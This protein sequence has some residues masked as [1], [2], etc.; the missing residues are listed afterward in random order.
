MNRENVSDARNKKREV[1]T[2]E[3]AANARHVLNLFI[4]TERE[5]EGQTDKEKT[6][7]IFTRGF[8][9]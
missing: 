6:S 9:Q 7:A 5:G 1:R 8:I 3:S 2:Y 4:Y